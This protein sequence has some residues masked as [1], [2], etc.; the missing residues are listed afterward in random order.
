MYAQFERH[1]DAVV[2]SVCGELVVKA[3]TTIGPVFKDDGSPHE[4]NNAKSLWARCSLGHDTPVSLGTMG[5]LHLQHNPPSS[6][7][8]G[9]IA[10]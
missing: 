9:L 3:G 7:Y 6:D 1:G 10:R 5:R 8:P 2:C 4:G